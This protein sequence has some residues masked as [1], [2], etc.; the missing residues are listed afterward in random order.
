MQNSLFLIQ[1]VFKITMGC[2]IQKQKNKQPTLGLSI[3]HKEIHSKEQL[4]TPD[5]QDVQS[6]RQQNIIVLKKLL[7]SSSLN[8]DQIIKP[9]LKKYSHSFLSR[10]KRSQQN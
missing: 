3:Q 2:N 7:A 4:Q 5:T 6:P 8:V 1:T 9:V 10:S